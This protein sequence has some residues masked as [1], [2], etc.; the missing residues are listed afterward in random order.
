MC[1]DKTPP[2]YNYDG[3]LAAKPIYASYKKEE[4]WKRSGKTLLTDF[5]Q[6]EPAT[7]FYKS[8]RVVLI[9]SNSN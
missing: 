9:G 8:R 2:R 6:Y 7:S 1:S 3:T 4:H 5:L